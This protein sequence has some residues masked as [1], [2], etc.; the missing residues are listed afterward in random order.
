MIP[1]VDEFLAC[2]R[3]AVVG[4]SHDPKDFSRSLYRA[5]RDRGYNLVPVNPNTRQ[6]EGE[7]CYPR[8][9]DIQPPVEAALLMTSPAVSEYVI[10]DCIAQGV[11]RVWL[12]RHAPAAESLAADAHLKMVAGECPFMFLQK[13][14]WFHSL[15]RWLRRP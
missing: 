1:N 4:V 9:R 7:P 8:L 15:H 14:G 2:R 5:F 11:Q 12:Y 6:I 13:P 10:K 3:I